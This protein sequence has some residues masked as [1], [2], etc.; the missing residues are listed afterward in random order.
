MYT[1]LPCSDLSQARATEKLDIITV[2]ST[3]KQEPAVDVDRLA[4]ATLDGPPVTLAFM[5]DDKNYVGDTC[6]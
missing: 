4:N 3:S 5:G 6:V 2:A 1:L